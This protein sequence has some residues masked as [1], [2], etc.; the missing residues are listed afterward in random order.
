[1][2]GYV[3]VAGTTEGA[4]IVTKLST[5]SVGDTVARLSALVAEKGLKLFAIIDHDGEAVANG[6]QLRETKLVI[7]G[8]PLAGTPVMDAHPL[9]ALDLPLKVLVWADAD[10]TKVSYVGVDELVARYGLSEALAGR[11]GAIDPLTD[12]LIGS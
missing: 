9:A 8:S 11:L 5:R 1:M 6:L 2:S 4:G 12:S 7:F 3:H 10:Q